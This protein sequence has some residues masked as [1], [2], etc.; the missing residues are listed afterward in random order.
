M[1]TDEI[2]LVTGASR[3]IG[4]AIALA[5]GRHGATVIGTVGTEEKAALAKS[6]GC[7]HP[8]LYGQEDFAEHVRELTGGEGV[9]VVYDSVGRDTFQGS[10]DCLRPLGLMVTFGQS[11]GSVP[12]MAVHELTGRGSLFLTRPTLATYIATREALTANCAELFEVVEQGAVKIE[13]NQ[14]YALAD[15][16]QAHRDLEN[17]KTTG[18]T[19][20]IP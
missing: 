3:G 12:P 8:I 5:L 13:I 10:L 17:R 14:T 2:G 9:P 20:L 7:D 19:V 1:L 16:A 11:S 15:A 6:H 18:A 4:Q